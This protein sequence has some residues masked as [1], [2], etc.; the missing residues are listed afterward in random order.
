MAGRWEGASSAPPARLPAGPSRGDGVSIHSRAGL[1]VFSINCMENQTFTPCQQASGCPDPLRPCI[2]EGTGLKRLKGRVGRM[3]APALP[4]T[5]VFRLA[6]F[7]GIELSKQEGWEG[8]RGFSL[9]GDVAPKPPR[10]PDIPC[11]PAHGPAAAPCPRAG[12]RV[13]SPWQVLEVTRRFPREPTMAQPHRGSGGGV[14]CPPSHT[15]GR[16]CLPSARRR[17]PWLL[18]KG[19]NNPFNLRS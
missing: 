11:A 12:R 1:Y 9:I 5:M 14:G 6:V 8:C 13:L 4:E 17:V 16:L 7:P 15:L 18:W 19:L 2:G 10:H 3:G